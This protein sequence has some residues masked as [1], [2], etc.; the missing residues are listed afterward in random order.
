MCVK[1]AIVDN[2]ILAVDEMR[3]FTRSGEGQNGG[4]IVCRRLEQM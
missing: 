1:G 2:A 4:L 3:F